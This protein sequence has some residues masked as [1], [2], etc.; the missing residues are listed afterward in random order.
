MVPKIDKFI[1]LISII[2]ENILISIDKIYPSNKV[3]TVF[4]YRE[5]IF[6][7]SKLGISGCFTVMSIIQNDKILKNMVLIRGCFLVGYPIPRNNCHP[8]KIPSDS[9][10]W[11]WWHNMRKRSWKIWAPIH[12]INWK[13]P[14][15]HKKRQKIQHTD[16]SL[17]FFDKL[18]RF[19]NGS[20][21]VLKLSENSVRGFAESRMWSGFCRVINHRK[22]HEI[23]FGKS[24]NIWQQW[25]FRNEWK[26]W[27]F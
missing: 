22:Y 1:I 14:W 5:M 16:F 19:P 11:Y 7:F 3:L 20:S 27:K 26:N 21:H 24:S 12:N 25:N 4:S 13:W 2:S 9:H 6:Y 17:S 8:Q 23:Y 15:S 10:P 18:S